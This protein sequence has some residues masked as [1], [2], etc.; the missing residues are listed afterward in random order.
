M[1]AIPDIVIVIFTFNLIQ[2]FIKL[3]NQQQHIIKYSTYY[4]NPHPFS[5][6]KFSL[7]LYVQ[8][9]FNTKRLEINGFVSLIFPKIISFI[10][11][12]DFK[13]A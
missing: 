13:K 12:F 4:I 9:M 1:Y 6:P 8:N 11:I 3:V 10:L 5:T 2:R 7:I